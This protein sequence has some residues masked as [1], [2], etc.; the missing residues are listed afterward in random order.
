MVDRLLDFN[1]L[2]TNG[3]GRITV[4]RSARTS[5]CFSTSH[6]D[7]LQRG[8]KMIKE[9]RGGG[10]A[11]QAERNM[12]RG[13]SPCTARGGWGTGT[14]LLVEHLTEKSGAILMWVRL[15]GTTG[16]SLSPR[17]NFQCGLSY[18]VR[19][20]PC[21]QSHASTPVRTLKIA[22]SGSHTIV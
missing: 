19:T 3:M 15:L 1:A 5:H 22:K 11:E 20:A 12:K 13:L 8:G 21:M 14:A 2:A 6:Q 18:G 4:T 9:K 17:V 10:G 16:D 7:R